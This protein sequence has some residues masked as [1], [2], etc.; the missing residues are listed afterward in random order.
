MINQ[1]RYHR[2][3]ILN[4][5]GEI[6]QVQLGEAKVLVIGAGGLGCPALMYLAGA[7]V[8]TIGII[9]FDRV[10]LDNLHRQPLF[11]TEDI[12]YPKALRAA[13]QL[14]KLNPEIQYDVFE[15]RLTTD[16][17][18][19]LVAAYDIILDCTDNFATRYMINDACVLKGKPLVYGAVSR[20][21]GQVAVFNV[22]TADEAVNYR[23]LFPD[24][25]K[26]SEVQSCAE[27]GVIGVLPGLIGT[28]QA[29]EAIKLIT[30][31]GKPLANRLYSYNFLS[32]THFELELQKRT[33]IPSKIPA[34][35]A[36]F[37]STDYQWLC[38]ETQPLIEI[39]P[40]QFDEWIVNDQAVIVDVREF[41]E[42]PSVTEFEHLRIPLSGLE[43]NLHR[44]PASQ[45][46][47]FFCQGGF[48]SLK[49]VEM[50]SGFSG[51]SEDIYS[52]RGGIVSWKSN[53]KIQQ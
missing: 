8:G 40:E 35:E 44:I 36:T 9:D 3:I 14:N 7:G 22:Q 6:S 16:N 4:G 25:P 11:T 46:V 5:F 28:M 32:N 17:C 18:L 48:R 42:Q 23:D 12:G 30:G 49:A 27:A 26:Q 47:I 2:Q 21:E 19:E 10:S 37:R 43:E 33:D 1:S 15:E 41:G 34:N 31:I 53:S 29:G 45:P 39:S 13:E 38:G 51:K 52:L 50:Y 20:Y 24:P